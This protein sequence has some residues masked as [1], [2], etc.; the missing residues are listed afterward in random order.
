LNIYQHEKV[1][2]FYFDYHN[3]FKLLYGA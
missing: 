3:I 2:I 1:I